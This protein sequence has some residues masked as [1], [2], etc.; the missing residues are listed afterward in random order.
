LAYSVKGER[1]FKIM[2]EFRFFLKKM[3]GKEKKESGSLRKAAA[4][5]FYRSLQPFPLAAFQRRLFKNPVEG[6]FGHFLPVKGFQ[7]R[8]G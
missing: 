1:T 8:M 4:D 2:A 3:A 7:L 5:E 6:F